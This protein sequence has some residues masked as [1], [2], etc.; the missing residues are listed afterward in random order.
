LLGS[1]SIGRVFGI[2][3]RVHWL[4]LAMVA[5]FVF[6]GAETPGQRLFL[7]FGFSV[8]SSVVLLHELGHSLVAKAFG[9]RVVDITFWPLGG[10]ARMSEIP[11]STRIEGL[12][13]IAGPMVNFVLA[14]LALPFA[15]LE[16]A[17]VLDFNY[18]GLEPPVQLATVFVT[19][20]L[21]LGLFNLIPAFPMDGGRVLRALLG[22]GGDWVAA[23]ETAVRIGRFFAVAMILWGLLGPGNM[24]ILPLIGVFVWFAGARELLAVRLRHGRSPLARAFGLAPDLDEDAAFA[25]NAPR[26]RP[27]QPTADP[28]DPSGARRPEGWEGISPGR[29]SDDDI[30]RL[31]RYRGRL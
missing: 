1:I 13:A 15:S 22:L 7:L 24:L 14:G 12:I 16:H 17:L 31:E 26:P 2:T 18:R 27:R 4:F 29:L 8:L 20:N 6:V 25:A 10:M 9:L 28:A 11:E 23:T 21:M 5:F 19:V 3:I 30:E